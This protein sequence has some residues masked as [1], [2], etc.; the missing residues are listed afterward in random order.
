MRDSNTTTHYQ[1]HIQCLIEFIISRPKLDQS[2]QVISDTIIALQNHAG[3]Q[4]HKL[5][6]FLIQCTRLIR[7]AIQCPESF[8][9]E[10]TAL[11]DAIIHLVP[12]LIVFNQ[13]LHSP[14]NGIRAYKIWLPRGGNLFQSYY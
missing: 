8:Q 11:S 12:E 10:M 7:P 9:T 4:S 5:Q 13:V 1:A 3:C 2:D 6:R 14:K